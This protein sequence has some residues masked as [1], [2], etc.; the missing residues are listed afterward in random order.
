MKLKTS[1]TKGN[2]AK[3][4]L[5]RRLVDDEGPLLTASTRFWNKELMLRLPK[6]K[7]RSA[8][9]EPLWEPLDEALSEGLDDALDEGDG[10]G[11]A[12]GL[13]LTISSSLLS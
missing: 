12:L 13:R 3:A 4:S 2:G 1:D 11:A 8:F 9:R 5:T 6:E 10:D 7:G